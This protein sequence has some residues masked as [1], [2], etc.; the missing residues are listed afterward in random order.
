MR[1][2]ADGRNVF[3]VDVYDRFLKDGKLSKSLS[4]DRIHP[5]TKGYRIIREALE[6]VLERIMKENRR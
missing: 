2:L 6:P 1:E 3:Y 4:A 5:T